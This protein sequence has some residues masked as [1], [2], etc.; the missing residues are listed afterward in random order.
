MQIISLKMKLL[1]IVSKSNNN[2]WIYSGSINLVETCELFA[3]YLKKYCIL[4]HHAKPLLVFKY[5]L[6]LIITISTL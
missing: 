3:F 5:W 4:D 2:N 1:Q 6:I